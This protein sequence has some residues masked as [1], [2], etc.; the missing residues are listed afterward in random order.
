MVPLEVTDE[1]LERVSLFLPDHAFLDA[2]RRQRRLVH[3]ALQDGVYNE[4]EQVVRVAEIERRD[5]S[6]GNI[7]TCT[8]AGAWLSLSLGASASAPLP[9]SLARFGGMSACRRS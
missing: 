8:S 4:V 7:S 9:S 2:Q 1:L 3:F 6:F 5:V